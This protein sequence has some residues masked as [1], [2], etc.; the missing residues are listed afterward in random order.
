MHCSLLDSTATVFL[1]T[2]QFQNILNNQCTLHNEK[3]WRY[4]ATSVYF[5]QTPR[6]QKYTADIPLRLQSSSV[7]SSTIASTSNQQWGHTK[8]NVAKWGILRFFHQVSLCHVS[9]VALCFVL[10][11]ASHNSQ[12]GNLL[13]KAIL[14]TWCCCNL[15]TSCI[16]ITDQSLC[17][18]VSLSLG[19]VLICIS[20][21]L[22][23]NRQKKKN[24]MTD[25][26]LQKSLLTNLFTNVC[27]VSEQD[28]LQQDAATAVEAETVTGSRTSRKCSKCKRRG[29]T[30]RNCPMGMGWT[31]E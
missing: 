5:N 31:S 20:L 28:I 15:D 13:K 9:G 26:R 30:R 3:C 1:V 16:V 29:H 17:F 25:H 11:F 12:L 21:S 10:I 19:N 8:R 14:F 24:V 6:W 2:V 7:H 4:Q 27:A 23:Q 22:F 18:Q